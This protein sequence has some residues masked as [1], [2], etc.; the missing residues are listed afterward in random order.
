MPVTCDD[1]SLP[2]Y[3]LCSSLVTHAQNKPHKHNDRDRSY[4]KSQHDSQEPDQNY[5]ITAP[6]AITGGIALCKSMANSDNNPQ[7][8]ANDENV[9][10]GEH[11]LKER[12][13]LGNDNNYINSYN[14]LDLV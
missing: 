8:Q 13:L 4:D 7:E 11:V 5:N 6:I 12:N 10:G 1:H 2:E 14:I 9:E 3:N